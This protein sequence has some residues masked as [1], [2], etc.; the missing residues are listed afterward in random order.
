[1][2][3]KFYWDPNAFQIHQNNP[4]AAL[5]KRAM[6]GVGVEVIPGDRGEPWDKDWLRDNPEQVDVLHLNWPHYHYD[7]GDLDGSL[8]R[9]AEFIEFLAYARALGYKVVWTMH[10]FYPHESTSHDLDRL[11]R[12]AIAQIASVVITHCDYAKQLVKKHFYRNENIFVI[13]HGNFID[14]YPNTISQADARTRLA[15]PHD[16]LIY[17]YF[18]NIR[19]YKG[20][21]NLVDAFGNLSD[22]DVTL[23]FAGKYYTDYGQQLIQ[24]LDNVDPRIALQPSA[25]I[26]YTDLQ[27]YLNAADVVVLPFLDVLT[28]GS[29]ITAMGF[30]RSVIVPAIGCLPELVNDEIG[31]LYNPKQPDGLEQALRIFRDCNRTALN[32]AAYHHAQSLAW[33]KI[34][35]QTLEAYQS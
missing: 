24:R 20:I 13:P 6:A 21:E 32:K 22:T 9:C 35:Q 17:L 10:N 18:G 1:M 16:H 14:A 19:P 25:H 5:L 8:Q 23:L 12:Q 28:S 3:A 15:L 30:S 11:V 27:I 31:I 7:T 34:A 29:A 26:P 33:D 2:R 4:Y